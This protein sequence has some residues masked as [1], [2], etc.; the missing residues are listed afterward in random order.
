MQ[1]TT[2]ARRH[3]STTA[4]VFMIIAASAPLTVLAGGVPTSFAVS[5]LLGVPLGYLVLGV[6]IMVFAL[7]ASIAAGAIMPLMT[8]RLL[9]VISL[10]EKNVL[11]AFH[12]A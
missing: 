7:L 4:V 1:Q 9:K 6:I 2:L 5:G 12:S 11:G 10:S 8:V 3:L